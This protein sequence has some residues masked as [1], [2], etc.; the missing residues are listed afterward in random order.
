M[1]YVLEIYLLKNE[2]LGVR[3]KL[4]N[5]EGGMGSHKKKYTLNTD[6]MGD[7]GGGNLTILYEKGID[8][9]SLMVLM[10]LKDSNLYLLLHDNLTAGEATKY[11]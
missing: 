2:G 10:N 1:G 7:W 11:D 4:R 3:N 6:Y 8:L 9:L 5:L